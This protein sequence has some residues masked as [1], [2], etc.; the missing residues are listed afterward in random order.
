SVR[1][2]FGSWVDL[3]A[4]YTHS[5]IDQSGG[6]AGFGGN[7]SGDEETYAINL[8]SGRRFART[9]LQVF[10]QQRE[11]NY[12]SGRVAELE[13]YGA[14]ASYVFNRLFRLNVTGGHDTNTFP[15]SRGNQSGPYW[16]VGGTWT[17]SPRTSLG[18]AWGKR[19]F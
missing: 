3:D 6:A 10:A 18:G 1:H 12:D 17:P 7:A 15:T 13:R 11:A 14:Q 16:T 5:T 2:S 4:S 19:F 9:P 8:A